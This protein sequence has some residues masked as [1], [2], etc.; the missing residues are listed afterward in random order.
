MDQMKILYI[1]MVLLIVFIIYNY[2]QISRFN[3]NKPIFYSHKLHEDLRITQ[4]T[5]YHS[6]S[7]IDKDKLMKKIQEF[8][9]DMI[10]LTGDILDKYTSDIDSALDLVRRLCSIN[11]NVFFVIGNHELQNTQGQKFISE[12]IQMG[13]KFL[14]NE[15]TLLE[16]NHNKINIIGLSFFA[17]AKDYEKVKESVDW[18]NYTLVLSH[19][20]NKLVSLVSGEE[21][22][23]LSG[24]I[25]GGQVRLP[26]IGAIIGPGQGLFPKYDK[27]V[28]KLGNTFL[29]IDSGL[30]NSFL[31]IRL[32]NR[33]QMSNIT[34]KPKL[35]N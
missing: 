34:V 31:P 32:F 19:S 7:L 30:G 14:D 23:V 18:N 21:D 24:H 1:F 12:M 3:I 28:F 29:Y 13:V 15:N 9:P 5:D 26:L 25:H 2:I 6:N 35:H 8:N 10:V 27:G 17:D 4:I 22:L 33:V 11:S 16:V 20:P